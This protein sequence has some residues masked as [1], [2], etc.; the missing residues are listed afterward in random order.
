LAFVFGKKNI[1]LLTTLTLIILNS[2]EEFFLSLGVKTDFDLIHSELNETVEWYANT[3]VTDS[4]SGSAINSYGTKQDLTVI[5]SNVPQKLIFESAGIL[6]N[7]HFFMYV[8]SNSS[9]GIMDKIVRSSET[10]FVQ[11]ISKEIY[12]KGV[13]ACRRYLI[14]KEVS[15]A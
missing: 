1:F 12:D 15:D 11:E 13:L 7:K 2:K 10:F 4:Q 9:V 6:T 14:K 8:K 5:I 3:I